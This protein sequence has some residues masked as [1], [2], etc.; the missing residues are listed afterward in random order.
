[1]NEQINW[2]NINSKLS[3]PFPAEVISWR[4]G[5]KTNDG[6]RAQALA[7]AEPRAY[8][9]RLNQV[10]GGNWSVTF[11]PWGENRIICELSI[12]GITRSSTGEENEGFA[13]GRAAEAQAFKRACSKFGLGRYLYDLPTSWVEYDN[14]RSRL[15]EEPSL[16]AR[17][18]PSRESV[19]SQYS[20][21]ASPLFSDA[22]PVS[23]APRL[24]T[25]RAQA[26]HTELAKLGIESREH[27]NFAKGVLR[28]KV[29]S[30][31]ELSEAE[32]LEIWHSAKQNS[33]HKQRAA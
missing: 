8:E 13:P 15:V 32:A 29:E 5:R 2:E 12:Y 14:K 23:P 17:F 3:T 21:V 18:L 1:M 33:S 11:K 9:D 7:Y 26:M 10:C 20:K 25:E 4:P 28:R 24:S 6:K 27:Y 22:Q 19:V 16:P 30:F 31:T